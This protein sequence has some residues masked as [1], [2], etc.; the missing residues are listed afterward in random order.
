MEATD[1]F[2]RGIG[3]G[4]D[5][6]SKEMYTFSDK[7]GRS[8]TLRPEGTAPIVRSYIQHSMD[9]VSSQNR[10]FYI[11]PMFRSERPQKE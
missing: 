1:V 6:V 4:T 7:K 10:L 2:T 9:Q 3:E 5:I 11:G 8:L